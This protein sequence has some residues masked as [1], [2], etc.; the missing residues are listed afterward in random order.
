MDEFE[1]RLF[2]VRLGAGREVGVLLRPLLALRPGGAKSARSTP[3]ARK[4][5]SPVG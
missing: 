4:P 2:V 3:W 5:P 1:Q